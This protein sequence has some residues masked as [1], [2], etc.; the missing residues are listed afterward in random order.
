VITQNSQT[1]LTTQPFDTAFG[2]HK[3]GRL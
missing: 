3:G 2:G 1:I